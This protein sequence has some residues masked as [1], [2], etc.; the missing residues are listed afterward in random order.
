MAIITNNNKVE[1]RK[2]SISASN[3]NQ[4]DTVI[5]SNSKNSVKHTAAE[6]KPSKPAKKRE[7][8]DTVVINLP[9]GERSNF[10]VFC[11]QNNLTMT[12]YIYF[13]MDFIKTGVETGKFTVGR[14]GIKEL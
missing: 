12:D 8:T 9:K 7:Y 11:A 13:A 14:S 6:D 5:N 2:N 3:L 10:K 1:S 4:L